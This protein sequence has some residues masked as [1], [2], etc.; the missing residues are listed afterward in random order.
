MLS[1]LV[2]LIVAV[3]SLCGL[4]VWFG[5]FIIVLKGLFPVCFLFGGI[6]AVIAGIA[7]WRKK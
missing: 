7:G 4:I 6:V 2:G 1:T 5:E 3:I